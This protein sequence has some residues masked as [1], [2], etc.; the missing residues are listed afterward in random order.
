MTPCL[1]FVNRFDF[2]LLDYT[3]PLL[4]KIIHV[5]RSDHIIKQTWQNKTFVFLHVFVGKYKVFRQ[6]QVPEFGIW[7]SPVDLGQGMTLG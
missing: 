5:L 7:T 2:T 4:Y 3:L 6:G 1:C